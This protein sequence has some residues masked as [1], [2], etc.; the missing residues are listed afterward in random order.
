MSS[1][2]NIPQFATAEYAGSGERCKSCNQPIA[3]QY[4]RINGSLACERCTEQLKTQQPKDSH[5][6][7]VNGVLLGI[8]GA[9]LGL[10]LYSGFTI[11]SGI[12][13]GYIS[14]AVGWMVGKAIR[15]G[16]GGI[17]GR[18][19]QI[20]ALALTYAAVSLS[21]VPIAI[22]E[23]IKQKKDAPPAQI[24]QQPAPSSDSSSSDSPEKAPVTGSDKPK[25]SF[26]SALLY[27]AFIG[28]ASPFLELQYPFHGVIGLIILFVGLRIAWQI[29]AGPKIDIIGPF[30][31]ASAPASTA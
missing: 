27:L 16:S 30:K 6:A 24:Q 15:K 4:Y 9:I 17:G 23:D 5:K 1:S 3:S 26:G 31:S 13:I 19:Y 8:G 7:F 28:L 20:V 25:P 12:Y 22:S 14:L 29:T 2:P 18:R 10:I 21:A 11:I